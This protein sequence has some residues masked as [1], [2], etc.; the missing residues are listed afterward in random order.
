[1]GGVGYIDAI[2]GKV[3]THVPEISAEPNEQQYAV[4][5]D[6]GVIRRV[7]NEKTGNR[8]KCHCDKLYFYLTVNALFMSECLPRWKYG[9][10]KR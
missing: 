6:F 1:M 7:D 3:L 2:V 9:H 8:D 10:E 4:C 5:N